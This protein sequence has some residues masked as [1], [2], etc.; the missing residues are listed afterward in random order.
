MKKIPSFLFYFFYFAAGS[1]LFPFMALYYQSTGLS[2]AEIGLLT[3]IAPL[4]TLVG[5]PFWTGMADASH[6]HKLI[7]SLLF[8]G[9]IISVL[10]IPSLTNFALLFPFILLYSFL[11]APLGSFG[12][13]ATMSMLGEQR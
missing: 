13:S 11:G 1:A 12:D 9:M 2:G 3:G 10:I 5:A 6:R 7:M 4:V 8:I